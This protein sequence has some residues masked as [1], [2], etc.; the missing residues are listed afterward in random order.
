MHSRNDVYDNFYD[1]FYEL[2]KAYDN[3][4]VN[5]VTMIER[6]ILEH[7]YVTCKDSFT[8]KTKL[9]KHLRKTH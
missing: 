9:F 8:L 7:I 1:E 4:N 3:Q 6:N 2:E 5:F